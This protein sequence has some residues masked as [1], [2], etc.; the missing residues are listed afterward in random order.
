M[1]KTQ[2]DTSTS[3][4]QLF[5]LSEE[6]V[7]NVDYYQPEEGEGERYVPPTI[8]EALDVSL[9]ETAQERARREAFSS[10]S[11]NP[12]EWYTA[13]SET[14]CGK[15]TD[16]HS[17]NGN[18]YAKLEDGTL[19]R[20]GDWKSPDCPDCTA[21]QMFQE[22]NAIVNENT[23]E[24]LES[25]GIE[26]RDSEG[27]RYD[28]CPEEKTCT[29][30]PKGQSSPHYYWTPNSWMDFL[31]GGPATQFARS[32][33]SVIPGAA[34]L[35]GAR[36][37][38]DRYFNLEK[39]TTVDFCDPGTSRFASKG[40]GVSPYGSGIPTVHIQA[41]RF[42][43]C[44][45]TGLSGAALTACQQN[46]SAQGCYP[47]YRITGKLVP[48]D[49]TF[50]FNIHLGEPSTA[51]QVYD[52]PRIA[53][54]GGLPFDIIGANSLIIT[55]PGIAD[56]DKVCIKFD[57][58]DDC[59][60]LDNGKICNRVYDTQDEHVLQVPTA[61]QVEAG[62]YTTAGGEGGPRTSSTSNGCRYC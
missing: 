45:C 48:K 36:P 43:V 8:E 44:P 18:I 33:S 34:D 27:N 3:G 28:S 41:Q 50:K 55:N 5:G 54:Q 49:C 37:W 59:L 62:E 2:E 57:E 46:A 19:H 15:L 51:N 52:K 14:T 16:I 1:A 25:E 10:L 7:G 56:F 9:E 24:R 20:I 40:V 21:E 30:S 29:A 53:E 12:N 4:F 39:F 23:G 17:E 6:G 47:V 61:A 22:G 31:R 35:T 58:G 13:C 26:Y 38:L 11:G 42:Y 60:A 32:L